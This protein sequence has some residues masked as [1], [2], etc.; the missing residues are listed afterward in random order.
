MKFYQFGGFQWVGFVLEVV[1]VCCFF[2][3]D[4]C[5]L[6][7]VSGYWQQ[8]V[9]VVVVF[10]YEFGVYGFE[11]QCCVVQCVFGGDVEYVEGKVVLWV[12]FGG[13]EEQYF[14]IGV[15]CCVV[16]CFLEFSF[17]CKVFVGLYCC[18]VFGDFINF[19]CVVFVCLYEVEV[20]VLLV[21]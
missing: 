13:V 19:V 10:C 5:Y 2:G 6:C 16:C 15:Q 12:K 7:E 14:Q 17:Q 9:E 18:V 3:S 11:L 4:D 21:G 1:Q 20:Q 8:V